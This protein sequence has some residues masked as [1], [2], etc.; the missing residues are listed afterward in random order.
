MPKQPTKRNPNSIN[1]AVDATIFIAFL[2][3]MAPR[4]S[5]IAIHE[6]LS[7]AFGAAIIAHLLLHWEWLIE[8]AK[9]FFSKAQWSSRIN[10]LLNI[11]L[12]IDI[13][14]IIFTG[15]LISESALPLLGISVPRFG[16]WRPLH[17]I[18]ADFSVFLLGLHIAM[19][20][21]WIVSTTKRFI[22][23]PFTTRTRTSISQTQKE[24]S[25]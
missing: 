18:S 24:V 12:F 20:W 16:I 4:F 19:H 21:Q 9:R 6:W 17:S 10:Y 11:L 2:I 8:V 14:I 1:L 25:Q 22:L 15:L 3:A 5:G 23:A 13:T 7:I